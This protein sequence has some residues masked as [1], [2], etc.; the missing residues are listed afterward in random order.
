MESHKIIDVVD[1]VFI[2]MIGKKAWQ[3]LK[4][5]IAEEYDF[6]VSSPDQMV[7]GRESFEKI[8]TSLLGP[9]TAVIFER[10]NQKL[11]GSFSIKDSDRF[12]YS[13]FGDYS[14]LIEALKNDS[15]EKNKDVEGKNKD[16]RDDREP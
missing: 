16:V 13:R 2:D 14:K 7:E 5:H 15:A 4:Y 11:T 8:L 6:D 12:T 9:G 1:S 3:A 10:I